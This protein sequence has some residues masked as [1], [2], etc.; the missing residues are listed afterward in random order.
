MAYMVLVSCG[1]SIK[2]AYS[3]NST[4]KVVSQLVGSVVTCPGKLVVKVDLMSGLQ[5]MFQGRRNREGAG[6]HT[7]FKSMFWSPH[8][9]GQVSKAI[10]THREKHTYI[11]EAI[12]PPCK[13]TL[14][15]GIT[16]PPQLSSHSLCSIKHKKRL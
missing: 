9:L 5:T 4:C 1:I 10:D 14:E 6:P 15:F 11:Q 7:I 3:N 2:V 12:Q 16:S 13:I 8:F